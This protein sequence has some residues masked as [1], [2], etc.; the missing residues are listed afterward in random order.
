MIFTNEEIKGIKIILLKFARYFNQKKWPIIIYSIIISS[1]IF[2]IL[3][4]DNDYYSS[5]FIVK[6]QKISSES[7]F[8]KINRFMSLVNDNNNIKM[9]LS[10]SLDLDVSFSLKPKIIDKTTTEIWT[11]SKQ[12]FDNEL[13][14]KYILNSVIVTGYHAKNLKEEKK[15]LK[16]I[17]ADI[18][19]YIKDADLIVDDAK[20]IESKYNLKTKKIEIEE[21]LNTIFVA[22]IEDVSQGVSKKKKLS[23]TFLTIIS[24][25]L[26]IIISIFLSLIFSFFLDN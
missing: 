5:I 19:K 11:K 26:G 8:Y 16:S 4:K 7:I 12:K 6:S 21:K 20:R 1:S 14:M 24:I 9:V 22:K 25:S 13:L 15:N 2:Y 17:L 3:N 23:F 10:D 18:S